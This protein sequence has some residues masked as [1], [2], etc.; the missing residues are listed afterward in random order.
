MELP[1]ILVLGL[2]APFIIALLNRVGWSSKTKQLVT[3]GVAIVLSLVWVVLTGGIAGFGF[4]S[5]AAAIPAIYALSQIVYEFLFKNVIAKLE[6]ATDPNSSVEI[7]EVPSSSGMPSEIRST[8]TPPSG[9][10][11]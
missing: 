8:S 5:I 9:P 6:S 2:V 11:A 4:E 7:P 1:L 10:L 3:F